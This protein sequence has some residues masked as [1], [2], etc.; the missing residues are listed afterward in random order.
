MH[1]LMQSTTLGLFLRTVSRGRIYGWPEYSD[2]ELVEWYLNAAA[3]QQRHQ[4][5]PATVVRQDTDQTHPRRRKRRPPQ[6]N[7][8]NGEEG[9]GD[10]DEKV[11]SESET[12]ME[13]KLDDE[14]PRDETAL[15]ASNTGA[16]AG[17]PLYRSPTQQDLEKGLDNDFILI[18]WLPDDPHNPQ[19][20]STGKKFFVTFQICLLTTSVYIGSAIYTAGI[21]DVMHQFHVGE[22]AALLGLSLFVI[23]YGL[24]PMVWVSGPFCL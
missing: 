16:S 4:Q 18:D 17:G 19:N 3:K 24:G 5:E 20:W 15:Q 22:V 9:G 21:E 2:P 14:K 11:E 10:H 7:A 12:D 8:E 13:D 1:D 23:G 6:P